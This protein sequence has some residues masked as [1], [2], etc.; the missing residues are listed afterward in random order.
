MKSKERTVS[1]YNLTEIAP[2]LSEERPF[3]R[4]A[5]GVYAIETRNDKPTNLRRIDK[6]RSLDGKTRKNLKRQ[7]RKDLKNAEQVESRS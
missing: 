7:K 4:M 5:R 2:K 1:L 3:F 6:N